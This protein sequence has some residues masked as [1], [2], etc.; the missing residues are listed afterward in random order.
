MPLDLTPFGFTPTE[1][2]V[3]QVLV[4][5]GP[6][7][8]YAVAKAAGLARANA[9]SALEGLVTK[10][11]ARVEEGRP[12]R[13][14]PEPPPV[15]LSRVVD[16]QG[17]AID[18]LAAS[19]RE[20]S[21]P[22]TTTLSEITSRRGL[23]Q[24]LSLEVAR[25]RSAVRLALPADAWSGLGPALRRASGV[26]VRLELYAQGPVEL[27]MAT[28]TEL[29]AADRWPGHPLLGVIDGATALLGAEGP[30]GG[31]VAG[32]WGT[33]PSLVAAAGL[34]LDALAAG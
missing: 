26:G 4:T 30:D 1:S 21:V 8:G 3:Y 9:Y 18:V 17:Q 7:T 12:R 33:A 31:G 23:L 5:S 20:I 6:G 22:A 15:L 13:Y 14:R 34:A 19:L 27:A 28:V 29:R 11:A 25:A 16:R 24:L 10:G 32:Y 2:L